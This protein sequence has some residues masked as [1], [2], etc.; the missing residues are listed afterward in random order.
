MILRECSVSYGQAKKNS[1]VSG[2]EWL[3]F[4]CSYERELN[5][6]LMILNFFHRDIELH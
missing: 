6:A 2:E 5:T 4:H 1:E 3:E